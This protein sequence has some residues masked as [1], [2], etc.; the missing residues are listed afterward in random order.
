MKN[1]VYSFAKTMEERISAHEI[2][3]LHNRE[4]KE[5]LTNIE[6]SRGKTEPKLIKLA[7]GYAREVFGWRGYAPWLYVYSAIAGNFKEGWIPINYYIKVV[8]PAIKGDYG[9]VSHLKPLAKKLFRTEL[10][11]DL[12]YYVNGLLLSKDDEIL[13]EN[14]LDE[15]L[16][17]DSDVIVYKADKSLQGRAVLLFTRSSFDIT[18]VK[19]LGNGVFQRYIDQH[20]FFREFMPSSVATLRVTTVFDDSGKPSVRAAYLRLGRSADTHVKSASHIRVPVNLKN[21]ELGEEGYLPNWHAVCKHPDT[22]TAFAGKRIPSFDKCISTVLALQRMLPYAQCIGWDIV[23]DKNENVQIM[24]WNGRN[25][26]IKFTEATQG[27]GF[28]DLGW[29]RL[30]CS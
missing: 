27:P 3:A 24:E 1:K 2:H 10:F 21:G 4:A 26:D 12:A 9:Y 29:E 15:F 19:L 8:D 30:W 16:F 6:R 14:Q 13:H 7:D 22:N 20:Q 25:N 18:K 17:R 11:P 5:A 28:S 23:L